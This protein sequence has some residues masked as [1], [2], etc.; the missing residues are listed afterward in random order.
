M[1]HVKQPPLKAGRTFH[2]KQKLTQEMNQNMNKEILFTYTKLPED[3]IQNVFDVYPAEQSSQGIDRCP[4]VLRHE[5]LALSD[6]S[7]AAPQRNRCLL[8]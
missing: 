7:N 2:V 6:S 8:Q 3:H 1:F 4:Q 5:F